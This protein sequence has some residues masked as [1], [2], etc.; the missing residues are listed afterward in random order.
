[1]ADQPGSMTT[2][3]AQRQFPCSHCGAMLLFEPGKD[4]LA[5]P[6]CGTQNPIPHSHDLVREQDFLSQLDS[7]PGR[8]DLVDAVTV[9][10]TTC[11]AET[12]LGPNVTAGRC[13]FCGSPIVTQGT[14]RQLIRP[15]SLLPFAIAREVA[16][17]LFAQ[18]LGSLWLAPSDLTKR[19]QSS[20]GLSGV[21]IPAWTYDCHTDSQY[22]GER[23]DDYWDTETYTTVE[24]G[25]TVT[26]T[27]QVRRTRWHGVS[28]EVADDFDDLL[29][30]ASQS[31]PA[32]QAAALEPWDL[33]HLVA[34]QDEYLSGFVAES[35]QID[36]AGGFERAKQLMQPTIESTIRSDIGGDHQRIASVHS[37][38]GAITFKHLLLPLWISAYRYQGKTYR[39][40]I[41]AR[42]GEVQGERPWSAVKIACLVIAILLLFILVLLLAQR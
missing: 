21:Y 30:L 38:Y 5:C 13:P 39:F 19:A 26:R 41:N 14:S 6:Y 3:T 29:V 18:W 25:K 27:R 37:T 12:T 31:L 23:G 36:L 10:C 33:Q 7:A 4:C 8:Q 42:T 32:K 11:G 2:T 22:T 17:R 24:N 1:M 28:G 34:Y 16:Q 20:G 40:L 35:Y 15:K 9:H